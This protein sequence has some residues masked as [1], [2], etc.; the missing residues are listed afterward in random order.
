[1]VTDMA[2]VTVTDM[3]QKNSKMK[4]A[5]VI[6]LVFF[7]GLFAQKSGINK[8]FMDLSVSPGED[9]YQ[10]ANG[11]WMK[12]AQIP[13]SDPSFGSF[14]EI[15]DR[16]EANL[17]KILEDCRADAKAP[18]GSTVQK[19]RDFYISGMDSISLEKQGLT[20]IKSYLTRIDAMKSLKELP[21][22][23]AYFHASG[24]HGMFMF[25]IE[26]DL[27]NSNENALYFSQPMLGLPNRDFFFEPQYE[28]LRSAYKNHLGKMFELMGSKA[29][30][31][32]KMASS[33]FE[34]E[35]NLAGASM[36]QLE[37][38]DVEKLYNK[39][40]L[41][42]FLNK[43]Q[44]FDFKKYMQAC[45]LKNLPNEIIISQPKYFEKYNQTLENLP[46]DVVKTYLKW[47]LINDASPFLS[48]KFEN[49]HFNYFMTK[50]NGVSTMKPR[51]K[52]VLKVLDENMGH[53]IGKIFVERHFSEEAKNKVNEMVDY[54]TLA[55]ENRIKSR[56]WMSEQTKIQALDKLK[57]IVRKLGFPE[58][59]KD[60]STVNIT[61]ESYLSNVI[62]AKQYGF[63]DMMARVGKPVDKKEFGMTPPTVNAYYNPTTNEI[64][65][66]AGI[67][68]P[69]FFDPEADEAANYG[70][71]GA[72]I[73]HELTHGF[74][75]EGCH[76]DADGNLRMWWTD[77]DF[78]KF[79]AKT[80]M[81]VKQFNEFI[82]VDTFRVNGMLTLG[83]NI[84]DLGGLT[85]AFNAYQLSLKGKKSPVID[86]FTG[87]QR[88]FLSWAQS[89]KTK[90]RPEYLKQM[91]ATNPH[92]PGNFR[93]F[94]PLMNLPQFYEAFG[95]KPGDKMYRQPNVRAEVW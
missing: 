24:F 94:A 8:S 44:N 56:E 34:L 63:A 3:D 39:V 54:L 71:M 10:Y 61:T 26:A 55:F 64:A 46:I 53:T 82:A 7:N 18:V 21:E 25:S 70:S 89:W 66:P 49:E 78:K 16:N 81:V 5:L 38:R 85:M 88:F 87:E 11:G 48:S 13:A 74:D 22:V 65:F 23:L 12:T 86:G 9:F 27:K 84:A 43:Y 31:A 41:T 32:N 30:K 35:K 28:G 58:N 62:K 76:F 36:N 92:S 4:H 93:A 40:G 6:A 73:G 91:I 1:M 2:M 95:I 17:R 19:I 37:M 29:D 79:S 33:V 75:D 83:E 60:Y 42:D 72:V 77:E 47:E 50:L 15:R 68:Q 20:P 45:G 80:E 51:W 14:N 57:H 59:W 69:P 90:M 67:M 52:R